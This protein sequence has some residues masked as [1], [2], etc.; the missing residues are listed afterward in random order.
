MAHTDYEVINLLKD[1]LMLLQ[2]HM[3]HFVEVQD[4]ALVA[5]HQLVSHLHNDSRV[6]EGF[7]AFLLATADSTGASKYECEDKG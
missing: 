3:P 6:T 1:Y 4:L 7:V 2:R 5:F